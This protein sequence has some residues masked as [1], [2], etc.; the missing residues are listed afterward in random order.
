MKRVRA[1]ERA[2]RSGRGAAG[3]ALSTSA[4]GP[5]QPPR[6][7]LREEVLEGASGCREANDSASPDSAG[8]GREGSDAWVDVEVTTSPQS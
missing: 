7:G 8:A 2:T 1:E 4:G 5:R 6:S 3:G